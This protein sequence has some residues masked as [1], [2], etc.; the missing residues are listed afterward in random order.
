MEIKTT[1]TDHFVPNKLPTIRQ[2][3]IYYIAKGLEEQALIYLQGEQIGKALL[4][5]CYLAEEPESCKTYNL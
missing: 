4:F 2:G 5:S 1:T 3:I